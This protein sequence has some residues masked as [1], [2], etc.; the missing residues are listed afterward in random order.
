MCDKAKK[1]LAFCMM[2]LLA[3]V[4]LQVIIGGT[5]R[6]TESGLSMTDWRLFKGVVPPTDEASWQAEFKRYQ[7]FPQFQELNQ[8]MTLD[9][10]KSIFF[11]EWL[12]R[13]WGRWGGLAVFLVFGFFLFRRQLDRRRIVQ[14]LILLLLYAAQGL[15]GWFMVKSGLVDQP[16]V[17]HF[18]LAAHLLLALFL[19]AYM[20]WMVVDLR[21]DTVKKTH[22]P[23]GRL[24][25]IAIL[26]LTVVQITFGAFMS[27]L[28]AATTSPTWPDINGSM[29][30]NNLFALDNFFDNFLY[31]HATIQF[32]HRMLG[33]LIALLVLGFWIKHHKI[34]ANAAHRWAMHALPL[35]VILQ[36]LLGICTLLMSVNRVPVSLGVAHQATALL[37]ISTVLFVIFLFEWRVES[38]P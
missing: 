23:N 24:L 9:E 2:L 15:L 37:F 35:I 38:R 10:F 13:V 33:Y 5:T 32:T 30:P 31:N 18:R 25:A 4:Y 22:N 14:F 12:H 19:F 34:A 3:I 26:I 21:S 36:V 17:S 29:I 28:R 7:Q 16:R 27:G 20:L 11:W 6:L 8:E 1:Q